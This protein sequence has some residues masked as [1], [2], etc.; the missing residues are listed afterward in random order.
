MSERLRWGAMDSRT[1]GSGL[2]WGTGG[3]G[4]RGRQFQHVNVRAGLRF[5]RARN[6]TETDPKTCQIHSV[7][8]ISMRSGRSFS[9]KA[10]PGPARTYQFDYLADDIERVDV[11]V[12]VDGFVFIRDYLRP[13]VGDLTPGEFQVTLSGIE[14]GPAIYVF[15]TID[16]ANR[17]AE[18]F[19]AT[20][21][22]CKAV[23]APERPMPTAG[24]ALDE[25]MSF[26]ERM[27]TVEGPLRGT[28]LEANG[29]EG[30]L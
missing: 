26:I 2:G 30:F 13:N 24:P 28:A 22:V 7:T 8:T 6:I 15:P 25:T 12:S 11:G 3:G 27:L 19:R 23:K 21:R 20:A 9:A 14:N 17:I 4:Q 1:V 18:A 29:R 10:S 16:L 5:P